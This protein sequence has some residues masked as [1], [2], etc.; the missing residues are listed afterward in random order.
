MISKISND[1]KYPETRNKIVTGRSNITNWLKTN[2]LDFY[3][4]LI[5]FYENI[6]IKEAIYMFYENIETRPICVMCRKPVK[7]HGYKYG[8][9]KYCCPTC[10]QLDNTTRERYINSMKQKYGEN[11]AEHVVN[12][13]KKTK[14]E[15]YGDENYNNLKK[16]K[17][18]C[19]E[20]YGVDNI[21]KLD[22]FKEKTKK[23]C[24]ERYG[25]SCYFSSEKFKSNKTENWNKIRK[26]CLERYGNENV[27]QV[28]EVKDKIIKNNMKKYGV[29]WSCLLP[30]VH[31]SRNKDSI[32]NI[33]AKNLLDEY[34]I[35][36]EREFPIKRYVFD[37]K[38][39]NILLEINPYATH[40]SNWSPFNKSQGVK[41]EYHQNKTNIGKNAGYRVI[42]VWDWDNIEL[43]I[44]SLI[45]KTSIYGRKC[46]IKE[47][48]KKTT[49]EFLN[50]YHFQGT[51][52]CQTYRYGLFYNDELVQIMTFGKPRYNNKYDYEL[53]R[54]CTK[55][56]YNIIG[57]AEK[58]F[59][60]FIKQH[61]PI[62]IISYCDESKFNGNVYKK[63]N[64]T[65]KTIPS[66]SKHWFNPKLN[67]HITDNFLRQKGYDNIFGTN[68]GKGTS[69]RELMLQNKFVE[70]YDAGQS[71]W[72]WHK[73]T[74]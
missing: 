8:F 3:N 72:I 6:D 70:I 23:T 25:A 15:R 28:K 43:I 64:F 39:G 10:A 74:K 73:L 21:M 14:L 63:L 40:N 13:G 24:L 45:N 20:K 11:Y 71:T 1:I 56:G 30:Q 60:Y 22:E 57:G 17:H 61:N 29:E 65:C 51:C 9:A 44:N 12:K 50:K 54:L 33:T 53:L 37:F 62:S 47:I 46:I 38:I 67:M 26:T 68:Y 66:P 52:K 41:K 59:K 48:D 34:N 7:F 5:S 49:K 35:E 18:T 31:N 16:M 69:N 32:P 27:M 19:V 2:Y 42:N 58:L 4:W 55:F 36:Y